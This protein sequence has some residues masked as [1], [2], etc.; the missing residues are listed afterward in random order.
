MGQVGGRQQLDEIYFVQK[1]KLGQGS[2]GTVWRGKNR[3]TGVTVAVKQMDKASLP[4]RGV[5]RQDIEREVKMMRACSHDNI[6]KLFDTFEDSGSIYMALEYCDGGDFGDKVREMGPVIKEADTAEWMRQMCAAL[7]HL[8]GR[9]IC[10]RDIKPDNFMVADDNILKMSD[11]GLAVDL[12]QGALLTDKC[13]TPAFMAPEQHLMPV[14]SR[15][16]SFPVDI[17]AAG[18]SMYMIVFG[19]RHP[20][21]NKRNELDQK[22]L[23]EGK[24]DFTDTSSVAAQGLGLIG[25]GEAIGLQKFSE[26]ARSFCRK[27]VQVNPASRLTAGNA[28]RVAWI[29]TGRQAA[30]QRRLSAQGAR[31][32]VT[33]TPNGGTPSPAYPQDG[34]T[35]K[36]GGR[37]GMDA[38]KAPPDIAPSHGPSQSEFD[39]LQKE[40]EA[41]KQKLLKG[42]EEVK[43]AKDFKTQRTK[44]AAAFETSPSTLMA[45]SAPRL[46]CRGLRCRYEPSSSSKFAFI[47]A[48][49][50][51]YNDMDCTYNLDVR[52]HADPYRISPAQDVSA[53]QAWPRGTLVFY[54]SEQM[55]KQGAAA[56]MAAVI[57]SFNE[58]DQTYNLDIREHADCD[59]IRVRVVPKEVREVSEP[60]LTSAMIR[61][62]PVE[63]RA[64]KHFS[65]TE[66]G[67]F[68]EMQTEAEA[69]AQSPGKML[70]I[71][72]GFWCHV[73]EHHLSAE[74]ISVRGG[75]AELDISGT[76]T[77]KKLEI[78]RAPKEKT[79]AWQKG[80]QVMYLSSSAGRWIDAHIESFNLHNSTYNLD[81]C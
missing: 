29:N 74:V 13:G 44:E 72:A 69:E 22:L 42:Q 46:L 27:L 5:S 21:L 63:K 75:I 51:G 24:L 11:F 1:V 37:F 45:T 18:V 35:P 26:N 9:G 60:G 36:A 49:V 50:D 34:R 78:L 16:Y 80:M 81:G 7:E 66:A 43:K 33:P 70:R 20:F 25:L 32:E 57:L 62:P 58:S 52:P 19:G 2:F 56:P 59:R 14:H 40:N 53:E 48:V 12:K 77:E 41:L 4:K 54:K 64:T 61:P 79:L 15:G 38:P 47:P 3:Q 39:H 8:H 28:L 73:P 10:H 68:C 67:K 23:L 6:T 30:E 55:E 76:V 65:A 17:W 31:G 71:A